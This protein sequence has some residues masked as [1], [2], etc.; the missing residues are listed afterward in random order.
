M[1][2]PNQD[3]AFMMSIIWTTIQMLV[4]SFFVSFNEVRQLSRLSSLP[5]LDAA[6]RRTGRGGGLWEALAEA[7][8][9]T[10]LWLTTLL[11]E[12]LWRQSAVAQ[13]AAH[14][15]GFRFCNKLYNTQLLP[16]DSKVVC[17]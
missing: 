12:Q 8:G 15:C 17:S 11:R 7:G 14:C 3:T 10:S 9:G 6:R 13:E 5:W 1:L 16:D 2:A 4:S